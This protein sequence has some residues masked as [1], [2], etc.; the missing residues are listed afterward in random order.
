[1]LDRITT[2]TVKKIKWNKINKSP[3]GLDSVSWVTGTSDHWRRSPGAER[4]PRA[5]RNHCLAQ[6]HL[7]RGG[8]LCG[9]Q[10][11]SHKFPTRLVRTFHPKPERFRLVASATVWRRCSCV[12]GSEL[13]QFAAAAAE[14]GRRLWGTSLCRWISKISTLE[15]CSSILSNSSW[16]FSCSSQKRTGVRDPCAPSVGVMKPAYGCCKLLPAAHWRQRR[17]GLKGESSCCLYLKSCLS[18]AVWNFCL[19]TEVSHFTKFRNRRKKKKQNRIK[20]WR[21]FQFTHKWL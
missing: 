7:Q 15:S 13:K 6:G 11:F 4:Q 17:H 19:W 3:P 21:S 1:M 9:L 2:L 18:A 10:K 8:S 20:N 16:G 12:N 5:P 14:S